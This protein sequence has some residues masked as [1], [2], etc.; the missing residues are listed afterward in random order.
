MSSNSVNID[1]QD[2]LLSSSSSSLSS[3]SQ[4]NPMN[5]LMSPIKS[6]V[7]KQI[8]YKPIHYSSGII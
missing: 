4:L 2:L 8:P 1:K 6:P 3:I 7:P 5:I